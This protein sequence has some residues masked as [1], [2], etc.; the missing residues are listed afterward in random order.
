MC[1][2]N[3]HG[4]FIKAQSKWYEGLP[5]PLEAEAL[6]LR[7]AILWLGD[8]GL[9]KVHIELDRKL[10]VDNI[11]DSSKNESEF[12]NIMATRGTLFFLGGVCRTILQQ[13]PNFK[14]SF[15]RQANC[16]ALSLVRASSC[17][18]LQGIQFIV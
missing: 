6:G 4:H 15:V 17:M 18:L 13:N 12:G 11:V 5:T 9:S 2:R 8:L 14:I 3:S 1:I 7:D 10:V 16:V